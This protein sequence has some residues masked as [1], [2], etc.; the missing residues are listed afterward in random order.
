[1][2]LADPLPYP[3]RPGRL[4][5]AFTKLFQS[6]FNG[7]FERREIVLNRQPHASDVDSIVFVPQ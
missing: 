1:L 4:P 5:F 2:R 7:A 3:Y 6:L